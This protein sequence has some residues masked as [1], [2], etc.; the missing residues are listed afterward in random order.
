MSGAISLP[1]EPIIMTDLRERRVVLYSDTP[2]LP[3]EVISGTLEAVPFLRG[4][5]QFLISDAMIRRAEE[6]HALWGIRHAEALLR[7]PEF[8]PPD[9]AGY[10]IPFPGTIMQYR[11][12][13]RCIACLD[14]A[15]HPP[16]WYLF[17]ADLDCQ[18]FGGGRLLRIAQES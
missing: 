3:N 1:V 4:E 2:V 8:I 14:S 13:K 17:I 16:R 11:G 5:E 12:G 18:F 7:H 15:H 10:Y 9:A 6:M